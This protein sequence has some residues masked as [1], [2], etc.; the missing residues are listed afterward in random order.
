MLDESFTAL[1]ED[2]E[3]LAGIDYAVNILIEVE[4][5]ID[6]KDL[7]TSTITLAADKLVDMIETFLTYVECYEGDVV[8]I[9]EII[10]FAGASVG[11]TPKSTS[12][13]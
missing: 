11:S 4:N 13:H 10:N 9:D 3:I 5:S 8:D 12:V 7:N 2:A 6:D 1:A